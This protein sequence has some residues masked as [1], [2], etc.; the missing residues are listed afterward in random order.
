[1]TERTLTKKVKILKDFEVNCV[2]LT[3]RPFGKNT[4]IQ[5]YYNTK[6]RNKI[7]RDRTLTLCNHCGRI[8]FGWGYI[9]PYCMKDTRIDLNEAYYKIGEYEGGNED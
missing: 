5:N 6:G 3:K 9:C 8:S 2:Y 1:M 4:L 7:M